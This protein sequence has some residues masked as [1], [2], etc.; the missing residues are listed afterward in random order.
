MHENVEEALEI[1]ARLEVQWRREGKPDVKKRKD[2]SGIAVNVDPLYT[3]QSVVFTAI[4][5]AQSAGRSDLI[6]IHGN[7]IFF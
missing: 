1:S 4:D 6:Q 7:M 3:Y 2:D 5:I